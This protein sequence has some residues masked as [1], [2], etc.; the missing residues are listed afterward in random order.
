MGGVGGETRGGVGTGRVAGVLDGRM[1]CRHSYV[2]VVVA[3]CNKGAH[4]SG[5]HV[6]KPELLTQ[7]GEWDT[8]GGMLDGGSPC[9]PGGVEVG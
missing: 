7:L 3:F 5:Q 4:R 8:H 9:N 1:P 6:V 2:P